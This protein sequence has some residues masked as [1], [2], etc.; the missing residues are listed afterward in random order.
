MTATGRTEEIEEI[1][2][3]FDVPGKLAA[4]RPYGSGHIND[5][6]LARWERAGGEP[7]EVI[8]QR[9]NTVVFREPEKVTENIV[10][11]TGEMR[12]RLEAR[13][14]AEID[15]RVLQL[16][17]ARDGAWR[18]IDAA[19]GYWRAMRYVHDAV[20]WDIPDDLAVIEE[21]ARIVGEFHEL[22]GELGGERLHETIPGF[23]DTPARF[24]FF[25]EAV[26]RD[27]LGRAARCRREIDFILG[28]EEIGTRC[29]QLYRQGLMPEYPTHN[30]TKI[31]NVLFD[32]TTRR[33]LCLIDLDTVMPGFR[34]SDI[35]DMIRT[36]TCT[37]AE[38]EPDIGRV[39][40]DMP[41]FEALARGY[42]KQA[43]G[44]MTPA[45]IEHFAFSG[46]WITLEQGMRFLGDHINGDV[47]YKIHR[48]GHNLDR[49]R[50]QIKLVEEIIARKDEMDGIVGKM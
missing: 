12:R 48:T 23:H 24:R 28:H 10:R 22:L 8:I 46:M 17:P 45:E 25:K 26:A 4:A 31:N 36:T 1:A 39:V 18:H 40:L 16:I 34:L 19:G 7:L 6:Y 35:G 32:R 20:T 3:R 38:D 42:L 43:G 14:E 5:T 15:R 37:A 27:P 9:L 21:G 49:A 11:V 47:Y 29:E 33:G 44:A 30:D 41:R 13:G 50:V 2:C